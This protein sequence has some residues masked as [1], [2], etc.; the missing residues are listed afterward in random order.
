MSSPAK[1]TAQI[2]DEWNRHAGHYAQTMVMISSKIYRA[3]LPFLQ[4]AEV[5]TVV[6]AACGPGNGVELLRQHIPPTARVLANDISATFVEMVRGKGYPN[7][8]VV[9][10]PNESLPYPDA[11]A[12]R[13]VANLSLHLVESPQRQIA[14]AFRVLRPG[15]IAA[16]SVVG[17]RE[18]SSLLDTCLRLNEKYGSTRFRNCAHLSNP[19]GFKQ[20][21][22]SI[23][24]SKVITYEEFCYLP[25]LDVPRLEETLV[26]H[27]LNAD[28]YHSL[29]EDKKTEFRTDLRGILGET[30]Q[31][32]PIGVM[33]R[34]AIA[35]KE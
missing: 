27:P 24:F 4:L 2:R 5:Q 9:E 12:D 7:V 17:D 15:G 18:K 33:T 10:A 3:M 22:T 35:F 34:V 25:V 29:S 28:L 30:L 26:Y 32:R 6:E 11:C 21:L 31:E 19:A 13:Y 14:E 20:L 1:P 16:I 23:G 8:E